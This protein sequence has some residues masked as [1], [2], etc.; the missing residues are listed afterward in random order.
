[1]GNYLDA[2]ELAMQLVYGRHYTPPWERCEKLSSVRFVRRQHSETLV[3]DVREPL[4]REIEEL[5]SRGWEIESKEELGNSFSH[6]FIYGPR[7]AR[8][9]LL[10]PP[11]HTEIFAPDTPSHDAREHLAREIEALFNGG[12]K[13]ESKIEQHTPVSLPPKP[14]VENKQLILIPPSFWDKGWAKSILAALILFGIL[15]FGY[16]AQKHN[17]TPV[18]DCDVTDCVAEPE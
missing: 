17:P 16:E 2:H 5:L 18:I 4:P 3:R 15:Y 9:R 1:M 11:E 14:Q 7:C 13:V 6:Q 8:I 12:W 10:Q